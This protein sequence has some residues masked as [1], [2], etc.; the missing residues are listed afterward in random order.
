MKKYK[1]T[2]LVNKP[3]YL[4]YIVEAENEEDA[5]QSIDGLTPINEEECLSSE[6]DIVSVEVLDDI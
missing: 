6:N 1:V 3:I 4:D 5:I 2:V